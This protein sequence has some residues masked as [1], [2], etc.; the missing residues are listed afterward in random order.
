VPTETI[1]LSAARR[2]ALAAQGFGRPRPR[3]RIETRHLREALGRLGLLQIDYV[4]VLVPAHY[5]PLF[6]RLGP[7]DR[8]LLDD[9]VYRQREFTEQ[10][11][12][13]ASILPTHCWP[14]VRHLMGMNDRRARALAQFM[15]KH[16]TYAQWVLEEV[17]TRGALVAEE[18]LEPDGTRGSRGDWWGWTTAKVTL[19]GHFASGALVVA[20]RR[21]AGFARAYDL[22]ERVIPQEHHACDVGREEA[23][24]E[25]LRRAA[26]AHGI[27][28]AADLADYYRMSIRETRS[29]IAEL[30][31]AKELREARVEGWR[32]PAY[33]HPEAKAPK[34]I[35]AAALLSP[36]DPVVWYRPRAERL[37]AF[38]Y[39]IEIYT[40]KEKRRWGYY[41]L[42]FLL[43]D[44]LVARVDLKADRKA[45]RLLVPAAHLERDADASAVAPA[46][47]KELR[48]MGEWLGLEAILVGKKGNLARALRAAVRGE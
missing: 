42:P 21:K 25:L 19:E 7:Y 31:A 34:R 15:E 43:G 4:N 6:S 45:R 11:A 23:H 29:R 30:V 36:F 41:V 17:R 40:P 22:A 37:F 13:E 33:V 27:G 47:A 2:I 39:R 24:R 48:K 20:E 1:S 35:T 3:G 44:R 18:V 28:T 38:D 16:A 9:L 5:L 46:L 26:R 14:L 12:H 8:S 32:E 10:W